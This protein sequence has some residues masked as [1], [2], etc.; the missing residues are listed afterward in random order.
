MSCASEE[1]VGD[2]I[3]GEKS[4]NG[5][6]LDLN[7]ALDEGSGSAGIATIAE[8]ARSRSGRRTARGSTADSTD[9]AS[10]AN[11]VRGGAECLESA[12]GNVLEGLTLEGVAER[13]G[14]LDLASLVGGELVR[15]VVDEHGALRVA[16]DDDLGVGALLDSLLDVGDHGLGTSAASDLR[17]NSTCVGS[18]VDALDGNLVFTEL[19]LE[20]V[21]ESGTDDA[22]H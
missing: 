22:A 13:D 4:S 8:M 21:G 12:L 14:G 1:S 16:R 10:A 5:I 15:S 11:G 19:L 17:G 20:G 7:L 9:A 6:C 3:Q 2:V 18:V